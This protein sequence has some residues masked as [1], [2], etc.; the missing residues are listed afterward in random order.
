[1]GLLQ[2]VSESQTGLELLLMS[3]EVAGAERLI[4]DG[5]QNLREG[6]KEL[7][8]QVQLLK[9][10]NGLMMH[11]Q[12]SYTPSSSLIQRLSTLTNTLSGEVGEQILEFLT[13]SQGV[14]A[15]RNIFR[16]LEQNRNQVQN[17]KKE[18]EDAWKP[19]KCRVSSSLL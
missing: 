19:R 1:M 18:I 11:K 3:A 12:I 4:T 16:S 2:Y 6:S 8:K 17:L 9:L 15:S 10:L 5:G 7:I 14:V 13:L